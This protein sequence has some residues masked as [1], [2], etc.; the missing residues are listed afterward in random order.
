MTRE[1][2]L[3]VATTLETLVAEPGVQLRWQETIRNAA[4]TLREWPEEPDTSGA[5]AFD[6]D[7]DGKVGGSKKK[8]KS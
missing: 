5:A 2:A 4:N 7:G 8:R 3:E 1:Q 6:H